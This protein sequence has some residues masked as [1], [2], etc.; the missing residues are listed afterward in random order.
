MKK[1]IL[2]FLIFIFTL[3][4]TSCMEIPDLNKP[5]LNIN[6]VV[7]DV[8]NVKESYVLGT[9]NIDDFALIVT[10]EDNS[11]RTVGLKLNMILAS[12]VSKLTLVGNHIVGINYKGFFIEFNILITKPIEDANLLESAKEKLLNKEYFPFNFSPSNVNS[13]SS[14]Q[15][16]KMSLFNESDSNDDIENVLYADDFYYSDISALQYNLSVIDIFKNNAEIFKTYLNSLIELVETFGLY[17]KLDDS[18]VY[19]KLVKDNLNTLEGLH[20][21]VLN[22]DDQTF[23]YYRLYNDQGKE[24][25]ELSITRTVTTTS[26]E[27]LNRTTTF[28]NID[29]TTIRVML[30]NEFIHR[31]LESFG[32]FINP[33][34]YELNIVDENDYELTQLTMSSS[35][36]SNEQGEIISIERDDISITK[37]IVSDDIL[38]STRISNRA[39]LLGR[40]TVEYFPNLNDPANYFYM[41]FNENGFQSLFTTIKLFDTLNYVTYQETT[42]NDNPVLIATSLTT[43]ETTITFNGPEF[44]FINSSSQENKYDIQFGSLYFSSIEE[45]FLVLKTAKTSYDLESIYQNRNILIQ[46]IQ[47]TKVFDVNYFSMNVSQWLNY[48]DTNYFVLNNPALQLFDPNAENDFI[49][50]FITGPVSISKAEFIELSSEDYKTLITVIDDTDGEIEVLSDSIS[51]IYENDDLKSILYTVSDQAGN[52]S[53]FVITIID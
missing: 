44:P 5:E 14:I 30:M 22:F 17:Q 35:L 8:T 42:F 49:R 29:N 21:Y 15:A 47:N 10:Y 18:N 24:V 16:F 1:I 45:M 32:K 27:T 2:I 36:R 52:I 34:M 31:G 4:L 11:T 3:N 40:F 48:L 37:S 20:F 7:L 33:M 39:D 6:D 50:P 38:Y 53:Q 13:S 23:T 12:D 26:S 46:D 51:I 28:Q 19:F 9:F 43:D 25:L 41:N